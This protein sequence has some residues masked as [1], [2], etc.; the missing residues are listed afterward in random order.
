MSRFEPVDAGIEPGDRLR[1][2]G[3]EAS[4]PDLARLDT[5][6]ELL[7]AKDMA[8]LYR[9]S[10]KRFYALAAEGA[11]VFAELRPRIGKMAWSR[12]RVRQHF[13]GEL[14]GLTVRKRA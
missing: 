3:H 1:E 8:V 11:F 9:V 10:L 5:F 14:R 2:R 7:R 12:E 6:P 13:A 4:Q